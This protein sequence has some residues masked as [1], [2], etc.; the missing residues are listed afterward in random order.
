MK[1]AEDGFT[2]VTLQGENDKLD[3]REAAGLANALGAEF[4]VSFHASE[5]GGPGPVI[6]YWDISNILGKTGV[7]FK[8]FE[9]PGGWA[10]AAGDHKATAAAVARKLVDNLRA[11]GMS[12]DGPF[13][14]PLVALEG[15]GCP[16][17]VVSLDG[18]ATLEGAS[19]AIDP[20]SIQLLAGVIADT[21]G[22]ELGAPRKPETGPPAA[23]QAQTE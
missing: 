16:G 23:A 11:S 21:L 8:P 5:Y 12:A 13:P 15:V 1:L 9:P 10:H 20:A 22:E 6:W 7:S 19:I 17:L 2:P 4:F 18:F 14:A 3:P